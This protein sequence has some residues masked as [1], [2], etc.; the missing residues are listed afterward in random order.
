MEIA[1]A[2]PVGTSL[3]KSKAYLDRCF[4]DGHICSHGMEEEEIGS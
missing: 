3:K 4:K 1:K 2:G